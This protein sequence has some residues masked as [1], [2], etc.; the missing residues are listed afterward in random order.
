[1]KIWA[2]KCP[3]TN[4]FIGFSGRPRRQAAVCN[5]VEP[6]LNAKLRRGDAHTDPFYSDS[7]GAKKGR[8]GKPKKK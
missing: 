7:Y 4:I 3:N 2:L 5:Y 1:M 6:K 8:A